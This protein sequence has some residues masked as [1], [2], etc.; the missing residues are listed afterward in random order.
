ME[1]FEGGGEED[2]AVRQRQQLL[3]VPRAGPGPEPFAPAAGEN[4]CGS[5][6]G[7]LVGGPRSRKGRGSLMECGRRSRRR[8]RRRAAACGIV[9]GSG[10]RVR[11]RNRGNCQRGDLRR[12]S[13][14]LRI[15]ETGRP[16]S[17]ILPSRMRTPGVWEVHSSRSSSKRASTGSRSACVAPVPLDARE[18]R[19]ARGGCRNYLSGFHCQIR[20]FKPTE[21]LPVRF[22]CP[23]PRARP[24]LRMSSVVCGCE[25]CTPIRQRTFSG[26]CFVGAYPSDRSA[27]HRDRVQR[28]LRS[29][30]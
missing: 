22:D 2:L 18:M 27:G 26:G 12:L 9:C 21:Q 15:S 17:L 23:F 24:I 5:H 19:M 7:N 29:R 20:R 8:A 14:I 25:A 3:G 30:P 6:G 10:R 13:A 4:E 16:N 11:T 28:G 1:P